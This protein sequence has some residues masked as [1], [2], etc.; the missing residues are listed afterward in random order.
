MPTLEERYRGCLAGLACGDAVGTAVEFMP[1]GSF[2]PVADMRGGGPFGL[3]PGQWTDDTSMALCLAESLLTKG[4]FV[5]RRLAGSGAVVFCERQ[6]FRIHGPGGREPGQRCRHHCSDR[7]PTGW[8]ILRSAA[9]S[10]RLDGA[11]SY[12]GRDRIDGQ[13]PVTG[14]RKALNER[15]IQ[16]YCEALAG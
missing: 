5:L 15:A 9:D 6:R 11:P 1:R 14:S 4:G 3:A 12:A 8:C 7:G 13:R 16:A 2:Q 10:R